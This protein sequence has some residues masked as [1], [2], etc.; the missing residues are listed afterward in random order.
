MTKGGFLYIA[1]LAA[2]G[3]LAVGVVSIK[4]ARIHE[5]IGISVV[6]SKK[7]VE[8]T[9]D[10]PPP[11]PPVDDAPKPK[12][13]KIASAANKPPPPAEA[14]VPSP[15]TAAGDAV[16]DFGLALGGGTGPGLAVATTH[17]ATAQPASPTGDAVSKKV[18]GAPAPLAADCT[19][20]PKKPKVITITQPAYTTDARE[21]GIAG[22]V[23]VEVTIDE[24]GHVSAA[25][26]LEGLGH[27]LDEAALSAARAATFEPGTRCGKPHVATFV[28]A[29][30][31][32]L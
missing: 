2:H 27:G 31:F 32:A 25:R 6:E 19:D 28:I 14:P 30:R 15:A 1:S 16:P 8:P 3:A 20:P 26:V 24:S 29:M 13:A 23:R 12:Q 22:K 5:T 17:T 18:L 9:K 10:T 11:P 4:G 21:A 7:K